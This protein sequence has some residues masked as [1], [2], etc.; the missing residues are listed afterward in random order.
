[1]KY[2]HYLVTLKNVAKNQ[3]TTLGVCILIYRNY[4]NE[5]TISNL[6]GVYGILI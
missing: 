1:M 3:E 2:Q 5:I 6:N 4:P